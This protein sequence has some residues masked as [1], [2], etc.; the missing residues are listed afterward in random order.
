MATINENLETLQT[1]KTD[2]KTGMEKNLGID[3]TGVPFTEY[4]AKLDELQLGGQPNFMPYLVKYIEQEDGTYEMQIN[5][6]VEGAEGERV[7]IGTLEV[8]DT[9]SQSLYIM[10]E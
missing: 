4:G 7:L 3:L 5:D 10:E 1:A 2:I 6:F 9:G 8:D